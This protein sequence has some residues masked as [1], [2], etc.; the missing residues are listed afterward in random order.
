[1]TTEPSKVRFNVLTLSEYLS[2]QVNRQDLVGLLVSFYGTSVTKSQLHS[3]N[4]LDQFW[5]G[6][7]TAMSELATINNNPKL[8]NEYLVCLEASED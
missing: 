4:A 7:Y 2:F 6:Y 3:D 1:M 5:N 8:L